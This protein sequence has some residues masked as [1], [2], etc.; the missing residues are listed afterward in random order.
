MFADTGEF[1][2]E[3]PPTIIDDVKFRVPV[4]VLGVGV[5]IGGCFIG[6]PLAGIA[7]EERTVGVSIIYCKDV[8]E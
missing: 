6:I 3:E 2:F 5:T 4:G 8:Y 7:V 1:E